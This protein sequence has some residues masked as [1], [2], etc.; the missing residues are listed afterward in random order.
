MNS[1]EKGAPFPNCVNKINKTKA[2]N[3]KDL[4]VV[5]P[6]YIL[7]EYRKIHSKILVY[8]IIT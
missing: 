8:D 2:N 3:A 7:K 4:D 6:V 1:Q 5:I